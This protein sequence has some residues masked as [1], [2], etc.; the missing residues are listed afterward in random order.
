MKASVIIPTRN[1]A[2]LLDRCLDSLHRQTLSREQFE[3]L[4]IDNGSSDNTAE[5]AARHAATLQ[6]SCRSAPEPGL[7]VGRH[8]GLKHAQADLLVFVD[9]DIE[10]SPAWLAS[11]LEAFDDQDVALVGGNNLPR[12]EQPPPAWLEKW[13]GQPVAQGRALGY[14]SILDF[15]EG[16]FDIDPGYV[17]GC[18]FAIRKDVLLA[19]AG[20]HP[21]GVPPERLRFRGDG[22]T[23][24][25][26]S[27]RRLG[28]RTRFHSG[29]SVQHFVPG[30]R[31]TLQ[32]FEQRAYAQGVSDSYSDIRRHGTCDLP[33]RT[34]VRHLARRGRQA[35]LRAKVS[36]F[37]ERD[38]VA[39]ELDQ[40]QLAAASAYWRGYA[41]HRGEVVADPALFAWV[42][43]ADYRT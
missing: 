41:F 4:V 31:M 2:N 25:S 24:V 26:E 7:H 27:I 40:V 17:W 16:C 38:A 3:V 5:V 12:F 32:Y 34:R 22:E 10:A 29:A 1:R 19:V 30:N 11:I 23:H 37:P 6:V 9:D 39:R 42:L 43:K 36:A 28:L 14:L 13:W 35:L 21:D 8:E 33:L 15:G 20:F 18:N